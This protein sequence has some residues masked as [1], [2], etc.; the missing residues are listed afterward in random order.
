MKSTTTGNGMN[1][2]NGGFNILIGNGAGKYLTNESYCVII[3]HNK[4]AVNSKGKDMIWLV[5]WN[6]PY[7][8]TN[9]D[10][11]IILLDYY[12]SFV[13][14]KKDSKDYRAGLAL[15][16]INRNNVSIGKN[17]RVLQ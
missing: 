7:L 4:L 12:K 6:E 10:I 16:I 11:K 15:R 13:K 14:T 2:P 9:P 1:I 3:G 5:D 17:A 8:V